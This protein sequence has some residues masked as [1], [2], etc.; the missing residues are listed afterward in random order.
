MDQVGLGFPQ[1]YEKFWIKPAE[2]Q[3]TEKDP[4]DKIFEENKY[5]YIMAHIA[6][7]CPA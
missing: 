5:L 1:A 6:P 4:E 2:K 3:S 7:V